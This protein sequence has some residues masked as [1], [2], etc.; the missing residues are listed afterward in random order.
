ML[1]QLRRRPPRLPAVQGSRAQFLQGRRGR[2]HRTHPGRPARRPG[3]DRPGREGRARQQG[4][5]P[6]HVH[7]AGRPLPRPDAEQPARRRRI[8]PRRRRGPPG[9]AR[10]HGAARCPPGHE[11]HR[12]HRRHRTQRRRTPV[13]PVLSAATLDR[14][15]RRGARQCRPDPDLPRVQPRHPRDPRLFFARDRRNP[16]R[17]R[18][19]RRPG[20]RLHERGHTGQRPARQTLP[21]RHPAVLALPD[22]TPDRNRVLAHRAAALGRRSGHRP[23]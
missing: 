13:G 21:R 8:A 12:A 1:R 4:R 3:A 7:L 22:R 20:H 9:T 14:H 15:R 18:R 19:N 10:H 16:D 6:D 11:H 17:H 5:R 2:A 23:H